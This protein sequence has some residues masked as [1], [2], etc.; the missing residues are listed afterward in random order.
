[1]WG[2]R[3]YA[4]TDGLINL[5]GLRKTDARLCDPWTVGSAPRALTA[6]PPHIT[7]LGKKRFIFFFLRGSIWP[8]KDISGRGGSRGTGA[9][10]PDAETAT[11]EFHHPCFDPFHHLVKTIMTINLTRLGTFSSG[12]CG[13]RPHL[14]AFAIARRSSYDGYASAGPYYSAEIA[15]NK[16]GRQ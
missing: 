2:T 14:R 8:K 9:Q 4:S 16:P 6:P 1:M 5:C 15:S 10:W 3:E 11:K 12:A 7:S 13:R